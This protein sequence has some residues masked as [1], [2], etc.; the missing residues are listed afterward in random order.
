M[1]ETWTEPI[2]YAAYEKALAADMN[3]YVRDNL[4]FLKRNV[5]LEDTEELEISTGAVTMTKSYHEIETE[6]GAAIDEL[7]TI[8]GITEGRILVI[9][10]HDAAHTVVVKNGTGNLIVGADI[11]LDD[12]NKHVIL[13]GDSAGNAQLLG[14]ASTSNVASGEGTVI[15]TATSVDITHGLATTPT[16]VQITPTATMGSASEFYVAT[17]GTTTFTVAV[18]VAPGSGFTFDWRAAI[19]EGQ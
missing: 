17:K 4:R 1:A 11:Y 15:A 7:D 10:A 2:S 3:T 5:L 8:S 12:A 14:V 13:I 16:R 6:G 9:K 18:D 19:G